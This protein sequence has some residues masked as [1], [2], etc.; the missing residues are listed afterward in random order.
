MTPPVLISSL[1]PLKATAEL[2]SIKKHAERDLS[3]FICIIIFLL[4]ASL[5]SS[6]FLMPEHRNKYPFVPQTSRLHSWR[7]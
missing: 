6:L 5:F 3:L 4:R 7:P 2:Y 1:A